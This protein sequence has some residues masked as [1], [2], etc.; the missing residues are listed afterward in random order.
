MPVSSLF[1]AKDAV[2][3]VSSSYRFLLNFETTNARPRDLF[4]RQHADE[5]HETANLAV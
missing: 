3:L 5:S 2:I 1:L 4:N